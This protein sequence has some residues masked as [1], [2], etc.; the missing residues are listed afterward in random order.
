M[1]LRVWSSGPVQNFTDAVSL[2]ESGS[3]GGDMSNWL[4]GLRR[5]SL[6]LVIACAALIATSGLT[7]AQSFAVTNLTNNTAS[8]A[9]YPDMVVDA[10]GNTYLALADSVK[11]IVV[12]TQFD[13]VKFNTQFTV[14]GS[15][16]AVPA[17]QPQMAIYL[18]AGPTPIIGLTWAAVHPGSNPTSY[19]VYAS[20]LDPGQTNFSSPTLVSA[21]TG[22][23]ALADSPRLG[24]DTSGKVNVVW[25][26]TA[27][28]ISQ[29][30]DGKTFTNTVNLASTSPVPNTGG[31]RVGVDVFGNIYV[32]WT[33]VAGANAP[34]SY[35]LG[36]AP[37]AVET[38]T[39]GGNFWMNE[40]LAN[41][42]PSPAN[43]RNLSNTDWASPNRSPS[44]I[45]RFP[46][47][48]F[49]CSFDNLS[50]FVDGTGR[51]HLLWSDQAPIE[52]ILTSKTE[53]TYQAGSPFAGD[54]AFSFPINLAS[55]PAASPQ[56]AVDSKGSFYVVWSGGPTGGATGPTNSQGIFFRR[57]DDGGDSFTNQLNVAPSVSIS[58]AYPQ[59]AVDSNSNVNIVWEQP[60]GVL[61]GDGSD[62]FNV[63]FARSTDK[64]A[65][66]PTVSQVSNTPSQL[67]FT[68]TNPVQR[69]PDNTTCGTVQLGVGVSAIPTI[70]WVNQA[71]G[72]AVADIDFATSTSPTAMISPNAV[73]LT[74][75]SATANFTITVNGF[76]A[77]ITFSCLDADKNAAL[78]SWLACSFNPPTLNPAQGNTDTLTITRQATPTSGMFISAPPSHNMPA[79]GSSMAWSMAFAA[80]CLMCLMMLATSRRRRFSGAVLTRGFLVMTLTV[81]LAAGLVSCGGG[82]SKGTSGTTGS[83]GT[84]GGGSTVTIHVAVQAQ[85]GGSTT[86]LG[87]VT[88]TAQ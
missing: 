78:P 48:F 15:A 47:G 84:G 9:S 61:K 12:F 36:V 25:G 54:V 28:W 2:H 62:M 7:H 43:T 83:I 87:T 58:P 72:S 76:S 68:A 64:G 37:G 71:S 35:C 3:Y 65:T 49:G 24:F 59:V 33:D 17:F 19:D 66:F 79:Y 88:I 73:S 80:L 56:V 46:N 45:Q 82:T 18:N 77:P 81:V 85:S 75:S 5:F 4:S 14:P 60:T 55:L 8:T 67:C 42:L 57:S 74:A 10:K 1:F 31:P 39:S 27:A 29:S 26:Q 51:M 40:T 21:I 30:V 34:G 23:V 86:T 16:A 32:A 50:L 13:G 44:D 53:F 38:A 20:R 6:L 70:A 11:G 22:P 69:T 41:N 52:D 63:V